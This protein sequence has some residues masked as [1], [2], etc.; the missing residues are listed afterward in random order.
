MINKSM[1][2][3]KSKND[4]KVA[5]SV[6]EAKPNELGGVHFSTHIKIF[7]PNTNQVLVQKR[8]DI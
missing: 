6:P 3:S 4:A 7:D 2:N 8:G 5:G 1:H